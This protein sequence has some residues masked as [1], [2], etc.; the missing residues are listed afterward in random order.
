M[1]KEPDHFQ[2]FFYNQFLISFSLYNT[3]KNE[4]IQDFLSFIFKFYINFN[5]T[6][7]NQNA[8]VIQ[9]LKFFEFS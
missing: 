3:F 1:S 9:T 7:I 6:T 4:I 5:F 8:Y 2:K